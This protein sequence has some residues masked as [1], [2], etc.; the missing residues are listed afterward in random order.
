MDSPLC[1]DLMSALSD[2]MMQEGLV[3]RPAELL[4]RYQVIARTWHCPLATACPRRR[5]LES[6]VRPRPIQLS[7]WPEAFQRER[8]AFGS[9]RDG[10]K[11]R[12]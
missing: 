12:P 2:Q 5:A 7:F 6:G 10:N 1:L 3:N 11:R 4:R 9:F 8:E